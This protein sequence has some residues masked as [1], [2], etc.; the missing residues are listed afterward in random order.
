MVSALHYS[1]GSGSRV[2]WT[3]TQEKSLAADFP[4]DLGQESDAQFVARTYLQFLWLPES[5]MPLKLLV[6]SLLRVTSEPSAPHALH[7]HL[8][9]L[10]QTTR[11]A[12][13]KYRVELPQI[14][15]NGGGAGEIEESMMWYALNQET[16][17]DDLWSRISEGPW[18]DENWRQ[19]W[20]ERM[21][22]RE[23]QIQTLLYCLKLS[24][25]GPPPPPPSQKKG[26]GKRS[27]TEAIV[28]PPLEDFLEVFMDK[29]STWQMTDGLGNDTRFIDKSSNDKPL[30]WLQ[31]FFENIVKPQFEAQL[32]DICSLMR[33]KIYPES[34]F[35]SSSGPSSPS[36]SRG[37]SPDIPNTQPGK[38]GTS[39]SM[40]EPS[41]ALSTTSSKAQRQPL[42]RNRSRSLSVSLALERERSVTTNPPKKRVLN[43]EISM[44]RAF[45]PKAHTGPKIDASKKTSSQVEA[46]PKKEKDEG[47][48][49]VEAT[50]TKPKLTRTQSQS[51]FGNAE[52][53]RSRARSFV[54][55]SSLRLGSGMEEQEE[56]EE[57]WRLPGSSSP[58][59][60]LL[61]PGRLVDDAQAAGVLANSTPTKRSRLR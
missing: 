40:R 52:E 8:K 55:Q 58:D 14:L 30:D 34:P 21:E 26:K 39:T 53:I 49:L 2:N 6:P 36:S 12:S 10:L 29:M 19:S 7:G 11:S 5:I 45:K 22:R 48:L 35:S 61:G 9:P 56:E 46:P 4:L 41:P 60:L 13:R 37:T 1:L 3:A 17:D 44:S 33:S 38:H 27:R 31:T 54:I 24:L 51:T 59:V 42:E 20:I 16:A 23:F 18:E 43:R 25:P 28:G 57:E 32:P 50:P 15:S 47:M